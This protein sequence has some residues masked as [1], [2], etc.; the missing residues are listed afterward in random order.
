MIKHDAAAKHDWMMRQPTRWQRFK[1]FI[2]HRDASGESLI[3]AI[4]AGVCMVALIVSACILLA[5]VSVGG[6]S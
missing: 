2:M 5:L 6:G 3:E 1:K 4:A